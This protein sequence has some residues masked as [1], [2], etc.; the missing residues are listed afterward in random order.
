M[1][2]K[3]S[4]YEAVPIKY[5]PHSLLLCLLKFISSIFS[6][7]YLAF[8]SRQDEQTASDFDVFTVNI[9]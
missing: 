8:N 6:A 9:S 2:H 4:L 5:C 1:L 7:I 3:E